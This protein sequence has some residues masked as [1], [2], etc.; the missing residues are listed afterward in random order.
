M[1][2]GYY[3]YNIWLEGTSKAWYM[4]GK[5]QATAAFIQS[6]KKLAQSFGPKLSFHFN[7]QYLIVRVAWN[8]KVFNYSIP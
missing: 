5:F 4:L 2:L 1:F 7:S 8:F 3:W 6:K